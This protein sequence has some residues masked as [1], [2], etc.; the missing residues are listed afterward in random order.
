LGGWKNFKGLS[1][2]KQFEVDICFFFQNTFENHEYQS[3]YPAWSITDLVIISKR[4]PPVWVGEKTSKNRWVPNSSRWIFGFFSKHVWEPQRYIITRY[5]IILITMN[6]NL[7]I[8]LDPQPVLLQFLI[9]DPLPYKYIAPVTKQTNQR[10]KTPGQT[11]K[12]TPG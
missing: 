11:D 8:W 6:I 4:E 9:L 1:G 7:D 3:W 2:F 12:Q 5:M 10:S